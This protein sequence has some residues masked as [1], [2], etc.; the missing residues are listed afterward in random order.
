MILS[1]HYSGVRGYECQCDDPLNQSGPTC[2][3]TSKPCDT[4][5][6]PEHSE[7]VTALDGFAGSVILVK[8]NEGYTSNG[9]IAK[10]VCKHLSVLTTL[11]YYLQRN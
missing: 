1:V 4:F 6:E 10:L 5:I 8:C 9:H 7:N 2:E 11:V 3:A